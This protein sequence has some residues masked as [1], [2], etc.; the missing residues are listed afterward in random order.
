MRDW[1]KYIIKKSL[2]LSK[3]SYCIRLLCLKLFNLNHH[4]DVVYNTFIIVTNLK[5]LL[6]LP[7][8]YGHYSFVTKEYHC[9]FSKIL[10]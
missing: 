6:M 5:N 10:L 1:I 3:S 8:G 7:Q 2:S 9:R 4:N